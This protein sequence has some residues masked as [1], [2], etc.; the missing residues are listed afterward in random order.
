MNYETFYGFEREPF[1]DIPDPKLFYSGPE[2]TRALV[3]L[4]HVVKKGRALGVLTGDVGCGKTTIARRILAELG[5]EDN[6]RSGLII[7]THPDFGP[8]WFTR[9]LGELL[10]LN[11]NSSGRTEMVTRITKKLYNRYENGKQ[12][13]ILI[14]EANNITNPEVYEEIRG[15]LNL[16]LEYRRL[17]TIILS[18]MQEMLDRIENNTSLRQRISTVVDLSPLNIN[19]TKEYIKYRI[20]QAGGRE[21]LFDEEAYRL[22]FEFSRGIPRTINVICDNALLE[23][24]LLKKKVVGGLILNRVGEELLLKE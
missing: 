13:V 23:G 9:K 3:K 8:E 6:Y 4:L 16:E 17:I 20:E 24:V 14:D 7:L 18:G 19:S 15:F 10:G 21:E 11:F 1:A 22:I 12:T 2:H 5:K